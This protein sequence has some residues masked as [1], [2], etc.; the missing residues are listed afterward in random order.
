MALDPTVDNGFSARNAWFLTHLCR[1]AY[2]DE[3]DVRKR[4]EELGFIP[5]T[6]Q[7][8]E[9]SP[10]AK[11]GM[12][13]DTQSFVVSH[14]DYILVTF[15]GSLGDADWVTNN[16]LFAMETQHGRV[17]RG[18]YEAV[19][20]VWGKMVP[21]I[22]ELQAENPDIP[23]FVCGHSLGAALATI[24]TSRL[25]LDEGI[26]V[27]AVYPVGGPRVFHEDYASRFDAVFKNR[28]FRLVNNNDIVPRF[29][30]DMEAVSLSLFSFRHAGIEIYINRS[31]NI[32][33]RGLWDSIAGRFQALL[34]GEISDGTA[35]HYPINYEEAM[36]SAATK[37]SKNMV[38]R[39]V[40]TLM[41][42][43]MEVAPS[44]KYVDKTG[45]SFAVTEELKKQMAEAGAVNT[46]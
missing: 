40:G 33:T 3:E 25:V 7:W 16:D 36:R 18:Q 2:L 4:C 41:D 30:F 6:F 38:S 26:T 21:A 44:A 43:V 45:P 42:A 37:E 8:I 5:S 17:H 1:V 27:R 13:H 32:G 23:I 34:G 9:K 31:G 39:T 29:P 19:E 15:R 22:K 20:T 35:D 24:A 46:I 12:D 10:D 28:H 11:P 14:G